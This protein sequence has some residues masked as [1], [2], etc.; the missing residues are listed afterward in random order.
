[1][2]FHARKMATTVKVRVRR[3]ITW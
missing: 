3:L 2:M 1:M